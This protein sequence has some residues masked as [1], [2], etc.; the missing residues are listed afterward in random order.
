MARKI[1][2]NLSKRTGLMKSDE[3]ATNMPRHTML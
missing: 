3:A 1:S 2:Y